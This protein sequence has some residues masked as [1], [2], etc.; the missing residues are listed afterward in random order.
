MG[1]ERVDY[2]QTLKGRM[3]VWKARAKYRSIPWNL[4][5][6]DLQALPLTCFYT[7]LPLDFMVNSPTLVSLDRVDSN[8]GYTKENVVF[9]C[10]IV[11]QMKLE[12]SVDQFVSTCR[13]IVEHSSPTKK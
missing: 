3:T 6:A 11:N 1:K 4:T 13:R 7:G 9:C 5:Y 2:V 8:G 12:M 10:A